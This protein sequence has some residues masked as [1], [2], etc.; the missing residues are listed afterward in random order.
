MPRR[1]RVVQ[2]VIAP[3]PK[4]HNVSIAK[5]INKLMYSGKKATAELEALSN[6]ESADRFDGLLAQ[7]D[8]TLVAARDAR[9]SVVGS[10]DVLLARTGQ[11]TSRESGRPHRAKCHRWSRVRSRPRRSRGQLRERGC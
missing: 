11:R 2:R 9:E 3:D 8:T 7:L 4:F 6:Q 10:F 1:A 5:F